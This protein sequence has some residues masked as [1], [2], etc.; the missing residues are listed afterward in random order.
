VIFKKIWRL[1]FQGWQWV[2]LPSLIGFS[3][4]LLAMILGL[5][6]PPR[7]AEWLLT[8]VIF[9]ITLALNAVTVAAI[10]KPM[11]RLLAAVRGLNQKRME[12][13]ANTAEPGLSGALAEQINQMAQRLLQEQEQVETM[14]AQ[15]TVRLRR[16]YQELLEQH[17]DLRRSLGTTQKAVEAQSE[18]FSNLS[19]ELRTPLTAILGYTDLLRRSPL[20]GEQQ[21]HL[22]TVGKSAQGM[23]EMINNL[24][25][26]GRIE[27]GRMKLNDDL[28]DLQQIIEDVTTLLAPLA[29]EK[30]LDLV[31]I[32]YEDVPRRVRGDAQR[33]RQ[34]IINLLSN[35]IKFTQTGE[36]VVRAM[37]DRTSEGRV[38]LNVSVSDTGPGISPEQQKRLFQAFQ[39]TA[40]T[41]GG[42][43]LGLT[44]TRKLTELMGGR[45]DMQS[46][47]GQGSTF[48]VVI[49]FRLAESHALPLERE[50][51]PLRGLDVWVMEPHPIAR[52]SLI[53]ALEHWQIAVRSFDTV[54]LLYGALHQAKPALIVLG[55]RT[56]DAQHP[57]YRAL[58][59]RCAAKQPPLLALVTSAAVEVHAELRRAGAASAQP[60]SLS[61]KTLRNEVQQLLSLSDAS[62]TPL[63]GQ[64]ALVADDN[65]VNRRYIA[66]LCREL[67]MVVTEA[68]NGQQV[69][70]H[71][72][73]TPVDVVLLDARMPGMDGLNCARIIRRE[74]PAK[75]IRLIIAS[76]YL[77]SA[78]RSALINAGVDGILIK[79]FDSQ[80]LLRI[81][82]PRSSA[83]LP[84]S[85]KLTTDP[86][87][88]QLLRE[89]LPLQLRDLEDALS[90]RELVAARDAAHQLHGTAAFYHLDALKSATVTMEQHL[91]NLTALEQAS[92]WNTQLGELQSALYQG[93]R[94]LA[95]A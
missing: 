43:G 75:R 20:D 78:E 8:L 24:L 54:S 93:L 6:E 68:A 63:A 41:Q 65:R 88:L 11:R 12:A 90:K 52:R 86:E 39:Q 13:R 31:H 36:V 53:H 84:P 19:H 67:G 51:T 59:Q 21:A 55:L 72:R 76:A 45:V 50:H 37:R 33:V 73:H 48:G 61:R 40:G 89:E 27:A 57:D 25:D 14:V 18:L 26:W 58:L 83:N 82:T 70:D 91:L 22:D 56:D 23:L 5:I 15:S 2:F 44:I 95:V 9:I 38:W 94:E 47:P 69:L 16:D 79:P 32:V 66:T 87:L 71:L 1:R 62:A 85:K 30:N 10:G 17:Q 77:E 49:P 46:T 35:A 80:E 3:M 42:S 81:L 28:L 74:D 29:Y 64:H 7:P 60:K 92:Q 4:A 34:I